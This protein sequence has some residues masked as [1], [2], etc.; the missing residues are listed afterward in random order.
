MHRPPP[1]ACRS[2]A[3]TLVELLVV[4]AILGML[5]ALALAAVQASR[6][7][8]RRAVCS[9]QL[10]QQL[11][12]LQAFHAAVGRFPAGRRWTARNVEYG[13]HVDLLPYLEQAGLAHN[14]DGRQPWNAPAN[15]AAAS[16][17]LRV[18][19]CPAARLK[20]PGKTDYGGIQGSL[21]ANHDTPGRFEF[22]NGVMIEL[23]RGR[24]AAVRLADVTDGASQTLAAAESLDRDPDGPGRWVSGLNCF[25][26]DNGQINGENGG[27]IFSLHP[28]GAFVGFAD[29]HVQFLSRSTDPSILGAL[30]TRD[31]GETV[32]PQ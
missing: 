5:T 24:L 21:L 27:E 32:N 22:N 7:A 1:R 19:V 23:G 10:R 18:L 28:G 25:S 17:D 30:C 14:L 9:N 11:V 13:W 2:Y 31:G 26:H 8:A 4:L 20:F 3:T 29:A 15:H 12:A 6:D 16:S